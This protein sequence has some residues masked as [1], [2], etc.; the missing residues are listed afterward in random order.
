MEN[1]AAQ[2]LAA[3]LALVGAGLSGVGIGLVYAA[4]AAEQSKRLGLALTAGLGI[5]CLLIAFVLIFVR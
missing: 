4:T 5:A 3:G 1:L 2:Y